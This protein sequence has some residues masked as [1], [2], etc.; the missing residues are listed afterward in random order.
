MTTAFILSCLLWVKGD[1]TTLQDVPVSEYGMAEIKHEKMGFLFEADV[2]EERMNSLK[3]S[4]I[5]KD[6]STMVY[7]YEFPQRTL[8][9]KLTAGTEEASLSCEIKQKL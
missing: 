7:S 9:T 4:H 5:Q 6:V 3:L 2:V 8:Y 1:F